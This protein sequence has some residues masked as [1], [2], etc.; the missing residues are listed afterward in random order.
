MS[1]SIK[2]NDTDCDAEDVTADKSSNSV[3]ESAVA[4]TH[5]ELTTSSADASVDDKDDDDT[6]EYDTFDEGESDDEDSG[7]SDDDDDDEEDSDT[8]I[9]SGNN[10]TTGYNVY[11]NFFSS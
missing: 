4:G 7:S 11:V 6:D 9:Y 10:I 5:Q 1:D 2:E 3:T 8:D